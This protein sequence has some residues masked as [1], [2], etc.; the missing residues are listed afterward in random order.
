MFAF[1]EI[2]LG[3][4]FFFFYISLAHTHI[5]VG[6]VVLSIFSSMHFHR[7]TSFYS[8]FQGFTGLVPHC[9]CCDLENI[10]NIFALKADKKQNNSSNCVYM[11]KAQKCYLVCAKML[12]NH[13]VGG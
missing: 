9:C 8:L 5:P 11:P 3:S 7:R 2:I 4:G 12:L 1:L 10:R 6:A 13:R